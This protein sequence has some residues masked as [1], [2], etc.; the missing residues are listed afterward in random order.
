[1][2]VDHTGMRLLINCLVGI[3]NP[4][5]SRSPLHRRRA[6][7]A[8]TLHFFFFFNLLVLECFAPLNAR[9]RFQNGD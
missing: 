2:R 7:R 4:S 3:A 6:R 8:S 5:S 9:V 1:M